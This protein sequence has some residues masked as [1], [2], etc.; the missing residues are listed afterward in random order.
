MSV[1]GADLPLCGNLCDFSLSGQIHL[2]ILVLVVLR[3]APGVRRREIFQHTG[4]CDFAIVK[5]ACLNSKWLKTTWRAI[6]ALV[7]KLK[8][9]ILNEFLVWLF[10]FI[11]IVQSATLNSYVTFKWYF[12]ISSNMV[13]IP[14]KSLQKSQKNIAAQSLFKSMQ[15]PHK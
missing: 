5:L 9:C 11:S 7:D 4:S 8:I 14:K 15:Y 10:I 2:Q 3:R 6:S 1:L 13:E 12:S